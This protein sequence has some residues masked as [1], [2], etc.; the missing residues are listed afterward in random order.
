MIAIA[1]PTAV[2]TLTLSL[3]IVCGA[4]AAVAATAIAAWLVRAIARD[5]LARA[6]PSDIPQIVNGLA[7]LLSHARPSGPVHRQPLPPRHPA[8][9][10]ERVTG[11]IDKG[12]A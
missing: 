9:D 11:L 3:W 7:N 5:A 6:R 12:G 1:Q 8:H 2:P 10:D 4:V